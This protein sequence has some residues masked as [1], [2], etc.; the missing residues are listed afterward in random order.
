MHINRA[1]AAA[2]FREYVQAYDPTVPKIALKVEHTWHVAALCAQIARAEGWPAEDVDLAWLAGLLHDLGRFE[3]VRRYGTFSDAR[4]ISHAALS[5]EQLFE[6]GLVARFVELSD[7]EAEELR[8]AGAEGGAGGAGAGGALTGDLRVLRDAIATHSDY[9]LPEQ[10]PR[11]RAL[12]NLL[13]D[14][15][16]IDILRVAGKYPLD[17]TYAFGDD[18]LR[19]SG[20]SAEVV[21][22]FYEHHAILT[23][24]KKQPADWILGH[25]SLAFELVYPVSRSI[26]MQQGHV[27][28]IFDHPIDVPETAATLTAARDDLLAYLASPDEAGEDA[29]REPTLS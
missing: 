13:R 18:D 9:R 20:V 23:A 6:D 29:A 25:A 22:A 14:A 11:T 16:K 24:L 17:V 21:A 12:S 1:Q 2:A 27:R 8:A 7:A 26:A 19:R 28:K 15:D 5:A 4:S 10:D 3:Q